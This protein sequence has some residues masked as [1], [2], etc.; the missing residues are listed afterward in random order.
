MK[1]APLLLTSLSTSS[2]RG[3]PRLHGQ[4]A[5]ATIEPKI[6][7]SLPSTILGVPSAPPCCAPG[8]WM[9]RPPTS[10]EDARF[11]RSAVTLFESRLTLYATHLLG[12][13]ERARD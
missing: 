7:L 11:I 5:H 2:R 6:S 9:S 4:D 1:N 8:D 12:D 3:V 10:P 13:V